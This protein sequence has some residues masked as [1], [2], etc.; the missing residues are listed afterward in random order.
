MTVHVRKA[1][2]GDTSDIVKL[3]EEFMAFLRR[4]N[5]HYWKIKDGRAAFSRYLMSAFREADV[6]VTVAEKK[7][8]GLV[9]FSLA[10]I[11]ILPEWF[12]SEQIGILRYQSVSENC[13]GRG[14]G[15]EMTS[16]VIDW[17]RSLGINRIELYVLKG[18]PA[19]EY[20]SKMG[21]KEFMDRRFMEI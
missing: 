19:S 9:G 2:E 10:Q 20:W 13:R 11:E 4:T 17:F 14:I 12:G 16:F 5:R 21:F 1:D 18:L 8:T 7:G 6:L 3:W 15:H